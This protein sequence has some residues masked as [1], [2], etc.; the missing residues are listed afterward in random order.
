LTD[1]HFYNS[2]IINYGV[3]DQDVDQ[4]GPGHRLWK[5]NVKHVN[6]TGR[7]LSIIADEADKGWLMI[8]RGVSEGMFLLVL[9]HQGNLRQRAIK[10]FLLL[11]CYILLT[12]SI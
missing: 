2:C 6:W 1:V 3:P 11:C 7:I 8:R 12:T 5:K 9:A 4:R 10:R